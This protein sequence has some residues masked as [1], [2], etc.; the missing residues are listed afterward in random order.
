MSIQF[1]VDNHMAYMDFKDEM[2]GFLQQLEDHMKKLNSKG[3]M[4]IMKS[5]ESL[6]KK[7]KKELVRVSTPPQK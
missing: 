2:D 3:I 6:P 5:I 1:Y 4:N 7:Y